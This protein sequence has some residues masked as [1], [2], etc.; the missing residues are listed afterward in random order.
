MRRVSKK[1][2]QLMR[3]VTKI[4]QRI[5]E[6]RGPRCQLCGRVRRLACHEIARGPDRSKALGARFAILAVCGECNTGPLDDNVIW[7]KERQLALLQ[8]QFPNEYSLDLFNVITAPRRYYQLDVDSFLPQLQG[9]H[10][11]NFLNERPTGR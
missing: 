8:I 7:P 11:G 6:Q 9:V 4:R 2:A 10:D 1:R 5:V 3:R